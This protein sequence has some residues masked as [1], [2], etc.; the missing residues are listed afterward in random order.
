LRS[1]GLSYGEI[2]RGLGLSRQRIAQILNNSRRSHS[3]GEKLLTISEAATVLGV[4]QNTL[5]RWTNSGILP[6]HRVGERRDRR[7]DKA[8]LQSFLSRMQQPTRH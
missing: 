3:A 6:A 2:G 7:F 1:T 4:H 5:R 8:D